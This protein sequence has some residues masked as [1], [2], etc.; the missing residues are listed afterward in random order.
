MVRGRARTVNR[1][2]SAFA[3]AAL[4][5]D[6]RGEMRGTPPLAD[7]HMCRTPSFR[8][9]TPRRVLGTDWHNV[10]RAY[11]TTRLW[12]YHYVACGSTLNGPKKAP[13]YVGGQF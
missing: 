5:D 7:E 9:R 6:P 1:S 13:P 11:A 2:G 12:P 10:G 8:S 4:G 3:R